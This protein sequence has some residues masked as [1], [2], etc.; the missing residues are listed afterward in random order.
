VGGSLLVILVLVAVM[1]ATIVVSLFVLRRVGD[2][3]EHRA[4]ILRAE[5]ASRGEEWE[6]PLAGAVYQG[7]GPAPR[8]KGHGVLGLTDRRVLFLPIAGDLV[9]VPR[10]RV[11]GI[12]VDD[13]RRDAA[14]S[15][16]HRLLVSLDDE[17]EVRF[18]VDDAPEWMR[19][20]SASAGSGERG[21]PGV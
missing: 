14:A 10:V 17:T 20:F 8:S 4:D 5:V 11:K 15:H 3:A 18:L 13:R 12:H 9:S 19:A 2:S 21:D 7:G 1:A 16:R 6:I